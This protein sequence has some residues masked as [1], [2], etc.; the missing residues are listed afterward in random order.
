M[1]N[2]IK[3]K[4]RVLLVIFDHIFDHGRI[5]FEWRE[6]IEYLA[7]SLISFYSY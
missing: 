1:V 4:Y 3:I 6:L 7:M 2:K 5:V